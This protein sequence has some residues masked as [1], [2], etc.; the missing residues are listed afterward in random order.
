[1]IN[2]RK[3]QCFIPDLVQAL[4]KKIKAPMLTPNSKIFQSMLNQLESNLEKRI[5]QGAFIKAIYQTIDSWTIQ[6]LNSI[7]E[8]C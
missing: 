1:M 2:L 7:L 4:T 5:F 3:F 8:Y 6:K